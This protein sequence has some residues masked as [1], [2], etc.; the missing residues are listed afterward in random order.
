MAH[1]K[2]YNSD[3]LNLIIFCQGWCRVDNMMFLKACSKCKG[4]MIQARDMYGDYVK[5]LQCGL[6][7]EQLNGT[8]VDPAK[9]ESAEDAEV[10]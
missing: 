7:T 5:C 4:D 3:A 8:L 6:I 2:S 9:V 1:V 10:A